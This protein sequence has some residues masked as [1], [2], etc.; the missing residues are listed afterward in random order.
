M[1]QIGES[2]AFATVTII[3]GVPY[4][5]KNSTIARERG[6]KGTLTRQK[7]HVGIRKWFITMNARCPSQ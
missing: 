2:S 6:S 7:G 1:P 3:I 4:D 5:L